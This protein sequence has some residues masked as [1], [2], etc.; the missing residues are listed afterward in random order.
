MP[1]VKERVHFTVAFD[2][3]DGG[4]ESLGLRASQLA[5]PVP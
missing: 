3:L 2:D 5:E 1:G 4:V